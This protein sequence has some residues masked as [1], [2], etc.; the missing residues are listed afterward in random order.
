MN[1]D[2]FFKMNKNRI[3]RL[4]HLKMFLKRKKNWFSK[5]ES[6][7]QRVAGSGCY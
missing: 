2:E 3:K 5:F 7:T 6:L 1:V 4:E